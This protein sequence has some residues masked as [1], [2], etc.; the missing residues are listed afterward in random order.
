MNG[1]EISGHQHFCMMADI[2]VQRCG[3]LH[4]VLLISAC[5]Q[6]FLDLQ[7]ADA[8]KRAEV[9]ERPGT[10]AEHLETSQERDTF[11]IHVNHQE[12]MRIQY[13]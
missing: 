3:P 6:Q 4:Q 10:W 1:N 5:V 7:G 11:T 13:A 12:L 2:I 8:E 9:P